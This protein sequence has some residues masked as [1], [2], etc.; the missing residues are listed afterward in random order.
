MPFTTLVLVPDREP[1]G[2]PQINIL[3][4]SEFLRHYAFRILLSYD[5]ITYIADGSTRRL[6]RS[7][8]CGHIEKG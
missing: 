1:P 8:S 6:D 4:G 3:I 5:S 7:V 2:P